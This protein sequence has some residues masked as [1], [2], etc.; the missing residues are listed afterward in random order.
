MQLFLGIERPASI[1]HTRQRSRSCD[2]RI[3]RSAGRTITSTEKVRPLRKRRFSFAIPDLTSLDG[4]GPSFTNK[5][6]GK[7][8]SGVKTDLKNYHR[9]DQGY[10]NSTPT[11][12]PT[13]QSRVSRGLVDIARKRGRIEKEDEE[14]TLTLRFKKIRG[15]TKNSQ[16]V[17]YQQLVVGRTKDSNFNV[18]SETVPSNF[19]V[20]KWSSVEWNSSL[21]ISEGNALSPP[22]GNDLSK[23]KN[24]GQLDTK[25]K[26]KS[27]EA[28]LSRTLPM[29]ENGR[30]PE[31]DTPRFASALD[32]FKEIIPDWDAMER[33]KLN[34][35]WC[36]ANKSDG[37]RCQWRMSLQTQDKIGKLLNDLAA[38]DI[39]KAPEWVTRLVELA[40]LAVCRNQVISVRTKVL[41]FAQS[42]SPKHNPKPSVGRTMSEGSFKATNKETPNHIRK[43]DEGDNHRSDQDVGKIGSSDLSPVNNVS[44]W[45]R[46]LPGT[47][48]QYLP[49]YL[50]YEA[51]EP[52]G[53]SRSQV[54]IKQAKKPLSTWNPNEL[55]SGYIYVYWNQ[56]T[57]GVM[58]IGSTSKNVDERLKEWE[59]QCNHIAEEQ[60]RSS[61][62]VRNVERVERLI[63]ADLKDYRVFEPACRGCWKSHIEWFTGVD[64]EVV[65]EKIEF[66]SQWA[67]NK[68]YERNKEGKWLLKEEFERELPQLCVM[69]EGSTE[70]TKRRLM[71]KA[72]KR[73]SRRTV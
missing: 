73:L 7:Q 20:S 22:T 68:P 15:R 40:N 38:M 21:F 34:P 19:H 49:E 69:R 63:H 42:K 56:A 58:K 70:K 1:A 46:K 54:I 36:L 33:F 10:K 51:P 14:I 27:S 62:L 53:C 3:E 25:E 11:E 24:D 43:R 61:V 31:L 39:E 9:L 30:R 26:S 6:D 57:F 32:K 17:V 13:N 12:E 71:T 45:L 23:Y 48:L 67:S 4:I 35:N 37:S 44:Y 55:R 72:S 5:E 50:P 64:I 2:G 16:S 8:F 29:D 52:S 41:E 66:W 65:R 18:N 59:R 47:A 60:Y 28:L